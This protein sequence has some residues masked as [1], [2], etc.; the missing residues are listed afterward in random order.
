MATNAQWM[1]YGANGYTGELIAREAAQRGLHPVLAGRNAQSVRALAEGLRLPWK[2]FPIEEAA[3]GVE[4]MTLVLNC[5]GPFTR[6]AAAMTSACLSAKAHYL[7]ITGE[8]AVFEHVFEKH[9]A[10]KSAGV[11]LMPGVGFDVIPSDCLALMLKERLPEATELEIAFSTTGGPSAGT[12]KTA[13]EQSHRGGCVRRKGKLVPVPVAHR[14][15]TIRFSCGDRNAVAIPWGDLSTAYRTTGIPNITTYTALP[16]SRA[17]LLKLSNRL[18]PILKKPKV[19]AWLGK[20][21]EKRVKGPTAQERERGRVNLWGRATS[22]KDSVE[23]TL[24]VPEGYRFTVLGSLAVVQRMLQLAPP[25]GA[26][27]PAAAYGAKLVLSLPETV[28]QWR[29]TN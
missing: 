10:A 29:E 14:Q 18:A 12:L 22:G 8:I 9:E 21:I 26:W 17:R 5:A 2:A 19:K 7:D 20:L 6:T 13:V 27:T 25:P 1:I 24:D 3:K 4:G 23:A 16:P 28:V 11:V 15:K